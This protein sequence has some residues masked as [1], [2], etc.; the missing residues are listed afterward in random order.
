MNPD[1]LLSQ[2][3]SNSAW[4]RLRAARSLLSFARDKHLPVIKIKFHQEDVP[5]V[6]QALGKVIDKLEGSQRKDRST[7]LDK[8]NDDYADEKNSIAE[9]RRD[10]IG[11]VLHELTPV[12]G[13]L[14]LAIIRQFESIDEGDVGKEFENLDRLIEMFESWR[15]V[16]SKLKEDEFE[17]KSLIEEVLEEESSEI[18]IQKATEDRLVINTDRTQLKVI[19]SNSIRNAIQAVELA[20]EGNLS[21][22]RSIVISWGSTKDSIWI[23][24][25][26][27][28]NGPSIDAENLFQ[29]TLTTKPGHKGLG[30]P[31]S[32]QAANSIGAEL[33]LTPRQEGGARFFFEM[34]KRG[35]K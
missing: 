20:S 18:E 31:I 24:V 17:L 19:L 23:S 25:L 8:R 5:W 10:T 29:S 34:P 32:Y 7:L 11:K 22:D 28:G 13:R 9:I 15:L 16:Q 3:D 14:K 26:D 30:L 2:L 27:D 6:K 35:N 12:V 4:Q 1:L 21:R 33:H